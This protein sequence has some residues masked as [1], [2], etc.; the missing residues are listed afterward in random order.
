MME[1]VSSVPMIGA[2]ETQFYDEWVLSVHVEVELIK[3]EKVVMSWKAFWRACRGL[4]HA[5]DVFLLCALINL[6]P[7]TMAA[8]STISL[9][10]HSQ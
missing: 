8:L 10:T 9:C 6:L 1:L 2:I 7:T 3:G 5:D 4:P